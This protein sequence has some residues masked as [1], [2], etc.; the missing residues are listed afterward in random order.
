MAF[1]ECPLAM[2]QCFPFRIPTFAF[3]E[4]RVAIKVNK[5]KDPTPN[6]PFRDRNAKIHRNLDT[7]IAEAVANQVEFTK[8]PEIDGF[9]KIQKSVEL[10][11]Y[12]EEYMKSL[13]VRLDGHI[14]FCIEKQQCC[15]DMMIS[16]RVE[17]IN[18]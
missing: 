11:K 13:F 12:S 14:L 9:V 6:C 5:H 2:C 16:Y 4:M 1:S 15:S 3:E 17:R 10:L 8:L 7:K 18:P